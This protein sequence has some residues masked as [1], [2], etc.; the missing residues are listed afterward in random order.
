[1]NWEAVGAVGEIIGAAVVMV[2]VVYLA[3]QVK[4][5]NAQVEQTN[6][7][8]QGTAYADWFNGW[9]EILKGWAA[10]ESTIEALRIGFDD[11]DAL[12]NTQK[13][14][15]SIQ[16]G[17]AANHWVL[18]GE[19][20]SRGLLPASLYEMATEVMVSLFSTPGGLAFLKFAENSFPNGPELLARVESGTAALPPWTVLSPWWS[21]A[22]RDA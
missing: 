22:S 17:A 5:A 2:S 13:A 15:F 20:S 21:E 14:I 19:L 1:M 3:L 6:L 9:N 7:Q 12:S 8:A 4:H 16:L 18:A 10:D 11:F